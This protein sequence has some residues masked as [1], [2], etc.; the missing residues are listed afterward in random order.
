MTSGS[1]PCLQKNAEK[2]SKA[3]GGYVHKLFRDIKPFL[4]PFFSRVCQHGGFFN[5]I[6]VPCLTIKKIGV[7][8]GSCG[9]HDFTTM[10]VSSYPSD[11]QLAE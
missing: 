10:R 9:G 2:A 7:Q 8:I 3:R 6:G 5:F 4:T 1:F 11:P